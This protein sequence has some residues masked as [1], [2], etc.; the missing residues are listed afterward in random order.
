MGLWPSTPNPKVSTRHWSMSCWDVTLEFVAGA[1]NFQTSPATSPTRRPHLSVVDR[2]VVVWRQMHAL[3]M[4]RSSPFWCRCQNSLQTP[5]KRC[6]KLFFFQNPM[7]SCQFGIWGLVFILGS[8]QVVKVHEKRQRFLQQNV[9]QKLTSVF[10]SWLVTSLHCF[11]RNCCLV[12]CWIYIFWYLN[13]SS[14]FFSLW[15][16]TPRFIEIHQDL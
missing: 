5:Q 13:Q 15:Y 1:P 6:W 14:F 16:E 11:I 12:R 3:A 10:F 9:R 8:F 7:K 4:I 2:R